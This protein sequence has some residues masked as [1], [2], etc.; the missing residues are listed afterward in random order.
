MIESSIQ[1]LVLARMAAPAPSFPCP[2]AALEI[3]SSG[4]EEEYRVT[5]KV[6][7]SGIN[8]SV[9]EC[10]RFNSFTSLS[11]VTCHLSPVSCHLSPVTCHL[12]PDE[13]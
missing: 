9:V 4:L 6:L 8:G 11:P 13:W 2:R 12:S 1:S 5:A 7:G 10:F 3:R